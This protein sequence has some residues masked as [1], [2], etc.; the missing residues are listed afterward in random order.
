LVR[1]LFAVCYFGHAFYYRVSFCTSVPN[2][3]RMRPSAAYK[4]TVMKLK[5]AA[6]TVLKFVCIAFLIT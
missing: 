6:A 5:M 1:I 3:M 4:G 2:L